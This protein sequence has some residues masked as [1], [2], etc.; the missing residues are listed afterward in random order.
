MATAEDPKKAQIAKYSDKNLKHVFSDLEHEDMPDEISDLL[1]A[2]R[3]QDDRATSDNDQ[4]RSAR[5]VGD[6]SSS[7][8]SVCPQ[9]D[10]L[11]IYRG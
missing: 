10:A 3:A 6:T 1:S 4:P 2:L 11:Q 7:A 9:V 8:Q 5:R